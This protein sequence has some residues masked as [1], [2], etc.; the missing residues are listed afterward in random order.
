[1]TPDE[2]TAQNRLNAQHSTGPRT[3]EGK[4]RSRMNA[5]KHGLLA[6][7]IILEGKEHDES[8]EEFDSLLHDLISEL[9]PV[10]TLE[11][12]Q[13]ERIASCYWRLKR[14]L[15]AEALAIHARYQPQQPDQKAEEDRFWRFIEGVR[16]RKQAERQRAE[17]GE[18]PVPA[19]P[20]L[21]ADSALRTDSA[22]KTDSALPAE[23]GRP[24]PAPVPELPQSTRQE[25]ALP[26]AD[27][28]LPLLRYETTIDRQ[29]QRA[30]DCFERLQARR[31]RAFDTYVRTRTRERNREAA[32]EQAQADALVNLLRSSSSGSEPY[33]DCRRSGS[34][35][36]SAEKPDLEIDG[37]CPQARRTEKP[38]LE[39]NRPCPLEHRAEKPDPERKPEPDETNPTRRSGS[40][41]PDTDT[42]DDRKDLH[43]DRKYGHEQTPGEN[44]PTTP[45]P[46]PVTPGLARGPVKP[47]PSVC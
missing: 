25:Y 7:S 39:I 41:E 20:I 34:E 37:P 46:P 43:E 29:L 11:D 1:M 16:K 45:I 12:M 8:P 22:L 36:R 38:D 40:L 9:C 23:P 14:V 27:I 5:L 26:T 30:L 13:V 44:A 2:R 3:A 47:D 28:F 33:S 4:A 18:S 6:K 19:D 35:A 24:A 17:R 32:R 10:G 21:H 42:H 15:R 31:F